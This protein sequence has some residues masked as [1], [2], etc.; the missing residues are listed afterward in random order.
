[1]AHVGRWSAGEGY[2]PALAGVVVCGM[3]DVPL[4]SLLKGSV[5]SRYRGGGLRVLTDC[6]VL[7]RDSELRR[8]RRRK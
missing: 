1:M 6:G 8:G 5:C 4:V 2:I 3:G 7:N